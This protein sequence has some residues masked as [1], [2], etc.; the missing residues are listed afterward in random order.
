MTS[1]HI[2]GLVTN[3]HICNTW[4]CVCVCV[5]VYV[6]VCVCMHTSSIC[7]NV[8]RVGASSVTKNSDNVSMVLSQWCTYTCIATS[9]F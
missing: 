3:T 9:Y 4:V 5:C 1:L 7:H 8:I 6:R 2:P